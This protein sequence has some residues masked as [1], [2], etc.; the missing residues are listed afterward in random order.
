MT[1]FNEDN[2]K[3]TIKE[4]GQELQVKGKELFMPIRIAATT[5]EHG[6]ELAK[7]ICLLGQ[8]K[9]LANIQKMK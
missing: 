1:E 9:V 7:V 5:S 3:K 4:L 2:I 6:P 8:K